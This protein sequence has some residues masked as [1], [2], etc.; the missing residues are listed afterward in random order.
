[1]PVVGQ[2]SSRGRRAGRPFE[3]EN[4]LREKSDLPKRINMIGAFKSPPRK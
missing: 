3:P 1:L 2:I 4:R